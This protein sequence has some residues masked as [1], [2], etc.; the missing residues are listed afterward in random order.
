MTNLQPGNLR[1]KKRGG[2]EHEIILTRTASMRERS[3]HAERQRAS[4]PQHQSIADA[5][6][7]NK[8]F[9]VV[10]AV[11]AAP[12]NMQ[13]Q[14][15]LGRRLFDPRVGQ[16]SRRQ[17]SCARLRRTMRYRRAGRFA[18]WLRSW[19]GLQARV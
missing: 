14:V 9:D 3:M 19:P 5:G 11:G 17:A 15:D 10:I 4:G 8:A 13:R 6:E 7:G 12:D 16:V 2:F 18:A 1:G